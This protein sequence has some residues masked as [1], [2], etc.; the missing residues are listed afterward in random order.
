M[1]SNGRIVWFDLM[2]TDTNAAKDF[3][4]AVVGWTTS[5]YGGDYQ[6]WN[7]PDGGIGGFMTLPA[8]AKAMGAPPHWV[9]YVSVP[10]L[11]A[12]IAKATGRGATV[13]V[14]ATNIEGGGRFALLA[15]PEGA[16]FG[17]HCHPEQGE[18]RSQAGLG[19]FS[20]TELACADLDQALAFYFDLFG[21]V[22]SDAMEMPGGGVYQM[23]KPAGDAYALG[24]AM[25]RPAQMPMSAWVFYF[26]VADCDAAFAA[27][28]ERGA[29]VRYPP[30]DI[31]GGGRA[32]LVADPQGATFGL[33][34][35]PKPQA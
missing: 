32:C 34:H 21:W 11:D 30:M 6:M 28:M 16:S 4:G 33:S 10:D 1:S 14:P 15:D 3:Y 8:E 31:P 26:R 24:G 9:G 20:W 25:K 7:A 12:T 2:T 18:R 23:F 13:L 29:T 17:V 5:T 35:D 22:K 27:A 19:Q